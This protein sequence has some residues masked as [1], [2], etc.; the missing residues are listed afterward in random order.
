MSHD[1]RQDDGPLI[2][3]GIW[4]PMVSEHNLRL[5]LKSSSAQLF[6]FLPDLI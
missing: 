2:H 3:P 1:K 5:P 6:T 4:I